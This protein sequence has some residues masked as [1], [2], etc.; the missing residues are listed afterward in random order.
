MLKSIA[1]WIGFRD[2]AIVSMLVS[3]SDLP[4][5]N[6]AALVSPIRVDVKEFYTVGMSDSFLHHLHVRL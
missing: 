2:M 4:L 5:K 6:N 1:L 3:A